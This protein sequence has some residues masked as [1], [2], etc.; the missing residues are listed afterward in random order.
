M[1]GVRD[2]TRREMSVEKEDKNSPYLDCFQKIHSQQAALQG[3]ILAWCK[4]GLRAQV[5]GHMEGRLRI[6]TERSEPGV[7]TASLTVHVCDPRIPA[8]CYQKKDF[9]EQKTQ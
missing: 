1:S 8:S 2:V 9:S 3:D 6:S 5:F 7:F 4:A